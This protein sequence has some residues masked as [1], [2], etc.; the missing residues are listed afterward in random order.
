M[1]LKKFGVADNT[2]LKTSFAL[3]CDDRL[4]PRHLRRKA[5]KEVFQQFY[6]HK[7]DR[8][9]K[10]PSIGWARPEKI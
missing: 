7:R 10:K 8:R 1:W 9:S 3:H 4:P 5:R 2:P 6:D